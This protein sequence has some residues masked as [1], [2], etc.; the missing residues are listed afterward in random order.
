MKTLS[1]ITKEEVNSFVSYD[2]ATGIF[3]WRN[4]SGRFGR[5]KA[6]AVAGYLNKEGYRYIRFNGVAYRACRLAWLIIYG[7]WPDGQIDHINRDTGDD[8]IKNL[9]D[10]TQSVNK[11]NCKIYRNNT[12][13][14]CG[15]SFDKQRK[16]WVANMSN[17][18]GK[19]KKIGRF[20]TAIAAH[21]AIIALT[22]EK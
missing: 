22:G 11:S 3:R 14:F 6:G 18:N 13:G 7:K 5:I 1:E 9:R 8:K 21:E 4:S 17:N 20:D 10:V 15:V 16:K 12:S 2:P 19:K